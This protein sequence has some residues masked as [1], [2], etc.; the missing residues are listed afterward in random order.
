M[1]KYKPR[2]FYAYAHSHPH[3]RSSVPASLFASAFGDLYFD[4]AAG[5][6][7]APPVPIADF[8]AFSADELITALPKFN[9]NVSSG[10][11]KLPS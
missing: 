7:A 9:G 10:L 8:S 11:S 3:A 1:L 4:D 2:Q 5:P 6:E